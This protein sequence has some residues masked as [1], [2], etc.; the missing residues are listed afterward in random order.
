M[1]KIETNQ[2]LF[3]TL[4]LLILLL[5]ID[6]YSYGQAVQPERWEN[7]VSNAWSLPDAPKEELDSL[8]Y[9][10]TAIEQELKH[11]TNKFAGTYL[12]GGE[13]RQTFLRWAPDN[14]FVYI[15]VYERLDVIDFSYGKVNITPSEVTLIIER[16]QR[17]KES[18]NK[19][20]I[21]PS[22]WI[23]VKWKNSRYLI[24]AERIADFGKYV[25]GFGVYNDFNGPC[26]E[27]IPFFV[28][29]D[30]TVS[31]ERYERPVLPEK[32]QAFIQSPIEAK[33]VYVGQKR[34][35]KDYASG[36]EL[37][38]HLHEK[39]SITPVRINVGRG[40]GIKRNM[41]FRL[42]GQPDFWQHLKITK[43]RKD[44]SEGIII[45]DLDDNGQ[46]NYLA[47]MD[48][49]EIKVFPPIIVG[50]KVTTSPR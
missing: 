12:I 50:Q 45:R 3:T 15:Y 37:Y 19:P 25:A 46:E 24:A 20:R 39:V 23:P 29:G 32:Y 43:V 14:G 38:G 11:S 18:E 7:G 36:G 9:R 48:P 21:T 31:D 17:S 5:I 49:R 40:S 1:R 4:I 10:W 2:N 22:L 30:E 8:K 42:E 47:E 34:V 27:F 16:E 6:E 13:M 33:I 26:C 28:K 35:M 41:L 44:F